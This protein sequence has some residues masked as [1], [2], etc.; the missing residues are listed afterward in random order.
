MHAR[1][2][3][4]ESIRALAEGSLRAGDL[5]ESDL[6]FVEPTWSVAEALTRMNDVDFDIAAV[7]DEPV[8]QYVVRSELSHATTDGTAVSLA[9]PIDVG[10]LVTTDLSLAEALDLLRDRGF[11]FVIRG[12]GVAG[13]ITPSDAQ[14]VPVSMVVLSLILATEAGL[15]RMIGVGYGSEAAW[16]TALPPRRRTAL[17]RRFEARTRWNTETSRLDLLMLEDRLS[18]LGRRPELRKRLGFASRKAFETWC[19]LLQRT[20]DELAHGHTLLDVRADPAKALDLVRQVR[21][22]ASSVWTVVAEDATE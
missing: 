10:H 18:L 22:F 2:Q 3:P 1:R 7:R 13:I 16:L 4:L 17:E 5:A 14:R 12:G 20:R 15:D 11:L 8:R 19:R 9:H 6:W 21:E